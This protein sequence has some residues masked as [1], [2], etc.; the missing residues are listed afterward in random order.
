MHTKGYRASRPVVLS[1]CADHNFEH[2]GA[3]TLSSVC[4][5][6]F[7]S[8]LGPRQR[9]QEW[10]QMLSKFGDAC[11]MGIIISQALVAADVFSMPRYERACYVQKCGVLEALLQ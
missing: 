3:L 1:S 4:Q 5:P 6:P 2:H 7:T 10:R 11:G 9:Q 8:K